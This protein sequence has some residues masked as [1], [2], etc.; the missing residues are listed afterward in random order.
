MSPY[1]KIQ[2]APLMVG[3]AIGVLQLAGSAIHAAVA[4][5]QDPCALLKSA[6]IQTLA[7]NAKIGSGVLDTSMAPLGVGCTYTWGPRTPIGANLESE[8]R[9]HVGAAL[10]GRPGWQGAHTGAPLQ[11]FASKLAPMPRTPEW[12]E[13]TLTITVIDASQGW[14]GLSP[15]LIQQGVLAQV[16]VGG[17]NAYQIPGVGD[18]A[19][20]TFEDRVSSATAQAYLKAKGVHLSV[21]F[22][23]GDSLSNKDKLIALLKDA[24]A[25]L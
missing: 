18:A 13:S 8:T 23:A 11:D 24:A 1:R 22:H 20:F 15:D 25:R 2:M 16:K 7:P 4:L 12:G 21:K 6:E 14:P 5:P 10:R 19:V 9:L 3:L 17:P